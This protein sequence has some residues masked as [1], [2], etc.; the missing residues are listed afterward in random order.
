MTAEWIEYVIERPGAPART[1]RRE[2]FDLVGPARR[3][4]GDLSGFTMSEATRLARATAMLGESWIDVS[5]A[6]IAPE[7]V[8]YLAGQNVLANKPLLDGMAADPSRA[9]PRTT[10]P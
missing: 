4:S 9:S 8:L 7:F 3:A 5:S 10:P 6:R 1:I 2:V